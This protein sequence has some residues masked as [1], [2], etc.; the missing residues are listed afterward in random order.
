MY[1]YSIWVFYLEAQKMSQ[2]ITLSEP[3][4]RRLSVWKA[5]HGATFD[6]A[7]NALLDHYDATTSPPAE[8]EEAV[9]THGAEES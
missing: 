7:V 2:K 1:K 3:V 5:Q 6:E 8:R 4:H 9:T